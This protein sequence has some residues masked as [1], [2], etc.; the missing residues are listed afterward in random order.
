MINSAVP[1]AVFP[2]CDHGEALMKPVIGKYVFVASLVSLPVLFAPSATS[3]LNPSA[4]A[5]GDRGTAI[6][7]KSCSVCH[8]AH[9]GETKVGPSLCGVLREGSG[10]SEGSSS[11][12]DCEWQRHYARVQRKTRSAPDRRSARIFEDSVVACRK[13]CHVRVL[14]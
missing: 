7:R 10:R 2:C 14:I 8:S 11:A 3:T 4:E 12:S 6:F 13:L 1:N 5:T 9:S